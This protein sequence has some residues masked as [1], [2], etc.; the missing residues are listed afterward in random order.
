MDKLAG[1][2]MTTA[3]DIA[4][5]LNLSVST[6][7]RAL[8]DDERISAETKFRVNQA[9]QELG[10]VASRAARMMRGV[11][12]TVI[13]LVVPDVRNSFYSTVA[14]ALSEAMGRRGHQVMLC[15]TGD[16]RHAELRQ[17][18]DLAAAQVA[19][20]I[21]VPTAKPHPDAVR[22][23]RS[24]P[25]V[26]LLRKVGSLAPCWFGIEDHAVIQTAAEHLLRLGHRRLGYVGGTAEL[27]TGTARLA[28]FQAAIA[29]AGLPP[30]AGAVELG[31]PS[32]AEHG[33]AALRALLSRDDPPT[34]IV[35]GA[36]Q[37]TRG[38][39]EAVHRDRIAVPRR[40]SVVGFG[41]EPG[42]SWWGPGLTTM[43][44]PMHDLATTCSMWLLHRL[45]TAADSEAPHSSLSPGTL[46]LRGST[47]APSPAREPRAREAAPE[48]RPGGPARAP[49]ADPPT[50]LPEPPPTAPQEP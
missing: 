44:L 32:S 46:V 37:V 13:G 26:Q 27:S 7:G 6:V 28:G 10:Y 16:D 20:I 1:P 4:A 30:A 23:L 3:R 40:L 43:S 5:R 11:P 15:E 38:L 21:I 9:A 47:A 48:R 19:G 31:P 33:A 2:D 36:V 22:L 14:H 8:A 12:S 25:H 17:I 39:L 42:F 24:I 35:T 45:E 29:A 49:A 34:G 41:D 50:P 18:R